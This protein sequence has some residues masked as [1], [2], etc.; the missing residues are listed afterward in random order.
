MTDQRRLGIWVVAAV[1]AIAVLLLAFWRSYPGFGSGAGLPRAGGSVIGFTAYAPQDRVE[2]PA[3]TGQ[4]LEGDELAL[5]SF[6]GHVLVLNVWGSWC[7]P[8]RAE[9][10]DLAQAASRTYRQGVRFV[11]IDIRDNPSA[12][13]AFARKYEIPY[14][15]LDDQGGQ[16]L[17]MFNGIVPIS[18]VPS[19]IFVDRDGRI[20]G[21]VI[22]RVDAATLR[23]EIGDLLAEGSGEQSGP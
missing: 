6:R 21:R 9:A 20:A 5:S 11:G 16:I 1:V 12:G 17:A 22:G 3:A 19:T 18:A 7:A 8:C 2:V 15:S 4:T 14:P 23:N 10:P 13:L